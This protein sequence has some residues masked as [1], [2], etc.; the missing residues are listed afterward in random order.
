MGGTRREVL[1][2]AGV[3]VLGGEVVVGVQDERRA[4]AARGPLPYY[5]GAAATELA[6]PSPCGARGCTRSVSPGTPDGIVGDAV[7]EVSSGSIL[8]AHDSGAPD[9]LLTIE[10]LRAILRGVNE[11]GLTFVKVSEV[12]GPRRVSR[13]TA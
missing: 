9:R 4:R 11:A 1:F 6:C 12:R 7:G 13:I 2:G 8:L 10:H 5:T 3:A